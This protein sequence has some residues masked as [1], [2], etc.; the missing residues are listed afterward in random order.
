MSKT[1]EEIDLIHWRI[2]NVCQMLIDLA[3]KVG[4]G[5]MAEEM[6]KFQNETVVAEVKKLRGEE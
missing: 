3:W 2:D 1:V 5:D 6:T 4:H